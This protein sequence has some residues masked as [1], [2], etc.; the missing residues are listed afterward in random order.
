M[1]FS[2]VLKE[3]DNLEKFSLLN[4]LIVIFSWRIDAQISAISGQLSDAR[5][6]QPVKLYQSIPFPEMKEEEIETE[7]LV[8]VSEN[9]FLFSFI[10]YYL[11]Q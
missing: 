8:E 3:N 6:F 11:S 4:L 10:L 2:L 5:I 1:F 9:H 7:V